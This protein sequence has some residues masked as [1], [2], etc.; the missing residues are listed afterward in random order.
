M[1]ETQTHT[2]V[3]ESALESGFVKPCTMGHPSSCVLHGKVLEQGSIAKVRGYCDKASTSFSLVENWIS[4]LVK[5]F[6]Y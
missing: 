6:E 2:P 1:N 3:L 5:C 4:D